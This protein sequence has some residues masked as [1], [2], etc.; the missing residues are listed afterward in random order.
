MRIED[1][2]SRVNGEDIRIIELTSGDRVI[3]AK[4]VKRD[5]Q[6]II[7]QGFNG[8]IYKTDYNLNQTTPLRKEGQYYFDF[9]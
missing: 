9:N 5:G 6:N 4:D 7:Y 1:K 3:T 2:V 8:D